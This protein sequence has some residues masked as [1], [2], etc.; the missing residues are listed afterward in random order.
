MNNTKKVNK[1]LIR[2]SLVTVI[3]VWIA[4]NIN[5]GGH[6]WDSILVYDSKGYYSY[7]PAVFIYNDLSFSFFDDIEEKYYSKYHAY[8]YRT[9]L[10]NDKYVNK[11]FAGTAL[12]ELPFFLAGHLCSW[13]AGLPTDGYSK[14][15]AIA[16]NL[17]SIFYLLIGLLYLERIFREFGIERGNQWI[18]ILS[19]IF[20][21][22]AFV[23]S[24][25]DP[26]MS[27]IYS[28]ACINALIYHT[29]EFKHKNLPKDFFFIC[30]F[31][32]LV[33]L[34]RPVNIIVILGIPFF[35]ESADD[36]LRTLNQIIRLRLKALLALFVTIC[37]GAIQLGIYKIQTGSWFIYSYQ[38]EGFNF[39]K[40]EIANFLISYRKGYF[41]YT[42]IAFIALFGLIYLYR[43]NRFKFWSLNLFLFMLVYVLSSWWCWWYG[44]SFSSRVMLEYTVFLFVPLGIL[45][46]AIK[47]QIGRCLLIG[48]LF[49]LVMVCQI[50]IYQLR[51]FQIHWSDM[52]KKSYWENF[53]KIDKLIDRN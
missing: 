18:I 11:Y 40:P 2:Y 48:L 36:L 15:Y 29:Y 9:K 10:S 38:N 53:L 34:I 5:W 16:I 23:Y 45:L 37:I 35:F 44:G 17:S 20:G 21:T 4:S 39:L 25:V 47:H 12:L 41:L 7:L 26:G 32:G 3:L 30:V 49:V 31:M 8:D 28:F 6:N 13:L 43:M 19:I 42:P 46:Q 33:I 27:H 22:N 14:Y 24:V 51:H 52:D 50:Q 1:K